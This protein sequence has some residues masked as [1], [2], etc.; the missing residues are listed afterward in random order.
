MPQLGPQIV[1]DGSDT[2]LVKWENVPQARTM[3]T[4]EISLGTP[5]IIVDAYGQEIRTR[6]LSGIESDGHSFPVVW[7][8]RPLK[9]GS[10][11]RVPWPL[12]AVRPA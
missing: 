9:D 6:A 1:A 2:P 8:E 12:E 10:T 5:V 11:D 7:V 3:E 4:T